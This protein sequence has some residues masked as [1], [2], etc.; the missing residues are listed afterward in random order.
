[1][2][3][4]VPE[5]VVRPA[6][7]PAPLAGPVGRA[8]G[9]PVAPPAASPPAAARV[10]LRHSLYLLPLGLAAT[11]TGLVDD[12]FAWL[13][14]GLGVAMLGPAGR[15]VSPGVGGGVA[16]VGGVVP[17][18][19]IDAAAAAAAR[20]ASARRLFRASLWHLPACMMALAWTREPQ[21]GVPAATMSRWRGGA[22]PPTSMSAARG[23]GAAAV[24]AE[25]EALSSWPPI[26]AARRAELLP[27]GRGAPKTLSEWAVWADGVGRRLRK[28]S[29]AGAGGG[30]APGGG[31]GPAVGGAWGGSGGSRRDQP[32]AVG[33]AGTGEAAAAP[34]T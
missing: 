5:S 2:L 13:Y 23:F 24:A 21:G 33:A 8:L 26:S 28:A 27:G 18:V 3:S 30:W 7:G 9:R 10:A 17:G 20:T 25:A 11:A 31:W 1:M 4:G 22:T 16:A 32:P 6:P 34:T 12:R 19:G 29:F 14:L 15:F